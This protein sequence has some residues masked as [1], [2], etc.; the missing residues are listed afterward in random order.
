MLIFPGAS[1]K[2]QAIYELTD[3]TG[4]ETYNSKQNTDTESRNHFLSA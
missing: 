1:E 4:S 3:S 2:S